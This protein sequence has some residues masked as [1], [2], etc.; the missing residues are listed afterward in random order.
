MTYITIIAI[1]KIKR[2]VKIRK[3]NNFGQLQKF[4]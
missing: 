4:T 3:A 2:P 1:S